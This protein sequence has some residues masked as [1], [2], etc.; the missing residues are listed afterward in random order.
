MWFLDPLTLLGDEQGEELQDFSLPQKLFFL[1][2]AF[3][4]PAIEL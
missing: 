2:P 3:G 4:F 1:Y